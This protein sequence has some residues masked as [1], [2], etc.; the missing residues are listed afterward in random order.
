[1]RTAN[2]SRY[3]LSLATERKREEREER[4]KKEKTERKRKRRY[5]ARDCG[6]QGRNGGLKEGGGERARKR[7]RIREK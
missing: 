6:K 5:R 3:V 2:G 4:K 7:K 1:M